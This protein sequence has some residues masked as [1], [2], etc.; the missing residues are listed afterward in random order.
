M[1][2]KRTR[3][4]FTAA[5]K[6]RAVKRLVAGGRGLSEVGEHD[7]LWGVSVVASPSPNFAVFSTQAIDI[8]SSA[9]GFAVYAATPSSP[10]RLRARRCSGVGVV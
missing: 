1:A 9:P 3:R 4:R 5:F 2:D 10:S 7:L 8:A 6:A